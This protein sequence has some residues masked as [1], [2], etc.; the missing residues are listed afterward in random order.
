MVTKFLRMHG[1]LASPRAAAPL[2]YQV[3]CRESGARTITTVT[4]HVEVAQN[5]AEDYVQSRPDAACD[6]S[7]N[8]VIVSEYRSHS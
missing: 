2:Q 8:G 1:R 6:I 3:K 7:V 5:T 4:P